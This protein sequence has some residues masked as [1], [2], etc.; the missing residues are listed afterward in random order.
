MT[1]NPS[2]IKDHMVR[3][4]HD[5]YLSLQS[6]QHELRGWTVRRRKAG[7]LPAGAMSIPD[8]IHFVLRKFWE[9]RLRKARHQKGGAA[10]VPAKDKSDHY[11]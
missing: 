5:L 9:E 6:L 7:L 1:T 10:D 8:T 4:P 2:V 11:P 3:V